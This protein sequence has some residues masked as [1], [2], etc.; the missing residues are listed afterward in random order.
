MLLTTVS[1]CDIKLISIKTSGV[2][3]PW[4]SWELIVNLYEYLNDY[5]ENILIKSCV[6]HYEFEFIHP[7]SD[8]NGRMGRLFQTCIL[9]KN[10]EVF[11]YLPIESIIKERQQEYYDSISKCNKLGNADIFIE[12]MLDAILETIKRVLDSS[13]I[14]MTG[15]SMYVE[16]LLSVMEDSKAY[17]SKEL[18]ELLNLKSI[19][20]FKKHYLNPAIECGIISMTIPDLPTSRSQRYMKRSN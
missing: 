7:F 14:E 10:E 19:A 12:F 9:A 2:W 13:K 3:F 6:Y 20:S 16:K 5:N 11:A 17:K 4:I 1:V 18:M 15:V 8:G